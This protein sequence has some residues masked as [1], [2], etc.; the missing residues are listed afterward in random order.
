M[1]H[2]EYNKKGFFLPDSIRSCAS[3]HAKILP[4]GEYM[5]RVHDCV[6]GIRLRGDLN[7]PDEVKEAVQKLESLANAA[8][9]FAHFIYSNY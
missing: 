7:N 3:F 9:D 6:S 4:T 8:A 5:F 2:V 1:T